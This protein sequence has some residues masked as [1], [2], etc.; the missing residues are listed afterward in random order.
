MHILRLRMHGVLSNELTN[1]L[2][3]KTPIL[4]VLRPDT[5]DILKAVMVTFCVEEELHPQNQGSKSE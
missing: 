3:A 5:L 1:L 4:G 2:P